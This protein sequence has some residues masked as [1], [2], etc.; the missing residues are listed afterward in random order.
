[1]QVFGLAQFTRLSCRY[2]Q[3][4]LKHQGSD[5]LTNMAGQSSYSTKMH[6][7]CMRVR[8]LPQSKFPDMYQLV[9]ASE[10]YM[11]LLTR[12]SVMPWAGKRNNFLVFGIGEI[13]TLLVERVRRRKDNK[14][15]TG[16]PRGK[17]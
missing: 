3:S 6:A 16:E 17:G 7:K 11:V 5:P 13:T 1:M 14:Y 15:S 12:T 10:K 8:K 9:A 2:S 4:N